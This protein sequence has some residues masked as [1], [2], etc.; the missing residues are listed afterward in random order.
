MVWLLDKENQKQY[1][2][3]ERREMPDR[4]R[5][6]EQHKDLECIATTRQRPQ[7]TREDGL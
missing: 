2:K 3:R 7:V 1:A 5:T 6:S 4:A